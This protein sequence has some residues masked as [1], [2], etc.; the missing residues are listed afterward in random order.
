MFQTLETYRRNGQNNHDSNGDQ[1]P[2]WSLL[3]PLCSGNKRVDDILLENGNYN[4]D[5]NNEGY[6]DHGD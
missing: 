5:S 6:Q 1:E 3:N 2:S 4:N